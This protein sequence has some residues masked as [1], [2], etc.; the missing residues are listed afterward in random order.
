MH[1]IDPNMMSRS[2][3]YLFESWPGFIFMAAALLV[4]TSGCIAPGGVEDLVVSLSLDEDVN[5][6]LKDISG[7]V[8][9]RNTGASPVTVGLYACPG[10]TAKS[11]I[12]EREFSIH[13]MTENDVGGP[14]VLRAGTSVSFAFTFSDDYI[15]YRSEMPEHPPGDY[16]LTAYMAQDVSSSNTVMFRLEDD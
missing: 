3:K 10:F 1:W 4:T 8:E 2:T 6:S 9:V 16:E 11:L 13:C 5:H 12:E 15:W 14:S 7:M